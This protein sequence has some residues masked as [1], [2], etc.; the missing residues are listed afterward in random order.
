MD[1]KQTGKIV[2]SN[3]RYQQL[4]QESVQGKFKRYEIFDRNGK[5]HLTSAQGQ[6]ILLIQD[7]NKD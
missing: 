2:V 3:P 5:I 7:I 6:C 4:N 1:G